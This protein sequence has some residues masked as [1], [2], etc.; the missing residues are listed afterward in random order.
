[1]NKKERKKAILWMWEHTKLIVNIL[2][3]LYV[4]NWIYCAVVIAIAIYTTGMFTYLDSLITEIG[5]TFRLVIGANM[6]KALIE[7]I[8]KYNDFG[9]KAQP[10]GEENEVYGSHSDPEGGNG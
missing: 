1:M 8:F 7:N 4:L 9:G 10:Y 3:A 2:T 5:D 6:C